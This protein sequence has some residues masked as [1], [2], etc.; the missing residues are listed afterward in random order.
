MQI[1][2]KL[3]L[4]Q[5]KFYNLLNCKINMCSLPQNISYQTQYVKLT[6]AKNNAF[7][8]QVIFKCYNRHSNGTSYLT[9]EVIPVKV[10]ESKM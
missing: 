5:K 9:V 2:L 8:N 4:M 6:L 1:Y 3:H 7:K 10:L